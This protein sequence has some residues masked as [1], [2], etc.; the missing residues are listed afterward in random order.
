MFFPCSSPSQS[1]FI[2]F[3]HFCLLLQNRAGLVSRGDLRRL[4][5]SLSFPLTD[6]QFRG[7]TD[8]LQVPQS[9]S[10]CYQH[11]LDFFQKERPAPVVSWYLC[12]I[13]S[14]QNFNYTVVLVTVDSL[15]VLCV[16]VSTAVELVCVCIRSRNRSVSLERSQWLRSR[17]RLNLIPP[18]QPGL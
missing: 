11:V 2:I 7:L 8:L 13:C 12:D 17:L 3:C 14:S 18:Q 10:I 16:S 4:L 6:E 15:V 9:G 5:E 1:P